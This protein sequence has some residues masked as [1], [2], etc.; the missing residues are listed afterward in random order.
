MDKEKLAAALLGGGE[1]AGETREILIPCK[2]DLGRA[3]IR[4]YI[5]GTASGPEDALEKAI[6]L[7]D[8]GWEIDV[9]QSK[10][11]SSPADRLTRGSASGQYGRSY[12]RW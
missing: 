1:N 12:R 4:V 5:R 10:S 9:W 3:S 6:E 8:Q 7:L 11:Y 2:L